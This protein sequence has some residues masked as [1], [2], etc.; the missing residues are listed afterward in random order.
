MHIGTTIDVSDVGNYSD[1]LNIEG[2]RI[3]SLALKASQLWANV[4]FVLDRP[5]IDAEDWEELTQK[6]TFP[7][8]ESSMPYFNER[9]MALVQVTVMKYYF[10]H[11]HE[12]VGKDKSET[13]KIVVQV[14]RG[15]SD[16]PHHD[17]L[18]ADLRLVFPRL[19]ITKNGYRHPDFNVEVEKRSGYKLDTLTGYEGADLVLSLSLIAGFRQSQPMGTAVVPTQFIP[20]SSA[21]MEMT[22]SKKYEGRNHLA[23]VLSA[24]LKEQD[25]ELISTLNK[26]RSPNEVK[27]DL[28]ATLI[29]ELPVVTLLQYD[30]IFVPANLPNKTV[31][32]K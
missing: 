17:Q 24:V 27:R 7:L 18:E 29:T 15:I 30:A 11:L 9:Q 14:H 10:K 5:F 20:T 22:L 16:K 12:L 3:P 28:V 25:D 6:S 21:N 19:E 8:K 26:V 23:E 31:V 2:A 32:I 1:G 13:A 4:A